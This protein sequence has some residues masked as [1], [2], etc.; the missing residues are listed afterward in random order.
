MKSNDEVR[1]A[2]PASAP[3]SAP[4]LAFEG[5]SFSYSGAPFMEGLSLA[6][7]EGGVTGII[8][9]N[10]S[11]KST[12]CRIAA[13]L[14]GPRDGVA[15]SVM[16]KG[17]SAH[18][19][20]ARERARVLAYMP[21]SPATAA[22]SVE[23]LVMCGRYAR[24][25]AFQAP[26]PEDRRAA[27]DAIE[28]VG[29]GGIRGR[30]VRSLSGGQRQCAHMAMMLAQ[31]APILLLDEPM[32]ALDI[33]ASHRM[34]GILRQAAATREA[35]VVIVLHDLDLALRYCDSL[36]V[37]DRGAVVAQGNPRCVVESGVFDSVFHVHVEV[38]ISSRGTAYA[39]FPSEGL[40][41]S[42]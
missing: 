35:T 39:F 1:T 13:G 25:R 12:L 40:R 33:Y 26:R 21:Q 5:I 37:M 18:S 24:M 22:M 11:G 20:P 42:N 41:S 38:H 6:I 30:E 19:L 28:L 34:M 4:A 17:R 15:G 29:L 7:A 2:R 16:A 27:D 32:S 3:A 36:V 8:G 23:E 10:G 31:Q 14:L 9:P